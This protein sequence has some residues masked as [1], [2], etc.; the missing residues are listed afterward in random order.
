MPDTLEQLLGQ[1]QSYKAGSDKATQEVIAALGAQ[2]AISTSAAGTYQQQAT[3]DITVQTA[4]NAADYQTQL[5]RV[6]AANIAGANLK[7]NSEV[8]TALSSAAADAQTRKDEALAAIAQKDS[9]GFIDNP[10]EYIMNQFTI[11]SD[12]SKHNIA[13]AQ[14]ES[15]Q[16][17]IMAVNAA[18]QT[19]I[20]TQN[21]ISEPL[22]AAS[23]EASARNAAVAANI[24]AKNAQIQALSYGTKGIEFA[25][26]AKKE[27]LALGFQEQTA[28]NAALHTGIALQQLEQSKKEFAARQ[29]EWAAKRDDKLEQQQLGQSV[30]DT[31]NLG[32]I[33]LLGPN[34]TPLDD[35]NGKMMLAALKG[36]GE[37]SVEMKKYYDAGERTKLAG[38]PII[39]TTP[40]AAMNTMQAIPQVYLNVTQGPIKDLLGQAA[41][42]T[43]NAIKIAES[44]MPG[45][46]AN[47]VF[48][49]IDKKDRS[50]ID[51]AFNGRAQQIL[52][53]Y[54]AVIKP[55]ASDNPN[56]IATINQ[57]AQNSPTIQAL[58]V[59]QKVFAPI[60]KQ[61]TQLAMNDPRIP[62]ILGD[63]VAK[64]TITHAQALEFSTFA[65]VGVIAN[66]A[67]RNFKGFGLVPSN[68]YNIPFV[69]NPNGFTTTEVVDI[70]KPDALSRALMKLQAA[71]L[72]QQLSKGI[73]DPN[74]G[75]MPGLV[76]RMNNP[77]LQTAGPRDF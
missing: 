31:V 74:S 25:L 4:K 49:G 26:N 60:I 48:V 18:A 61:G 52:N 11:N 28:K 40:A 38:A 22:T 7:N 68:S 43:S 41:Q 77:N 75:F 47:P 69:T 67:M 32:R 27:V 12:I 24:A 1:V 66:Q 42:D 65:H 64:G 13:N 50:S 51:A 36:K 62:D 8:L 59:F 19:T 56:Q 9:V 17:R 15:A 21:A 55:G 45:K 76:D 3:D 53:G 35:I 34:A 70:S 44:G 23:M 2:S 72:Q 5:S 10:F 16:N 30:I 20:Q 57:L 14:L 46:N 58:P 63:A 39:G 37:L 73:P 33:A 29:E 6:K 71:R 54:S